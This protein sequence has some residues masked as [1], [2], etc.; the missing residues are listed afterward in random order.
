LHVPEP[1]QV[2]VVQPKPSSVHAVPLVRL[3]HD[4]ALV[5]GW[6]VWHP[7]ELRAPLE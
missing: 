2:S 5:D 7:F 1:S 4:V 6:H 3:V